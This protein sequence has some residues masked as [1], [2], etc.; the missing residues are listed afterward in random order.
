MFFFQTSLWHYLALR[1]VQDLDER[2]NLHS[3]NF[4]H[5]PFLFTTRIQAH[6]SNGL[7]E[8]RTVG[9]NLFVFIADIILMR[10]SLA[11]WFETN[12]DTLK[13]FELFVY[14]EAITMRKS[15][16]ALD[17]FQGR[18]GWTLGIPNRLLHTV[19]NQRPLDFNLFSLFYNTLGIWTFHHV[20]ESMRRRRSSG[21]T[22]RPRRSR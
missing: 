1:I 21:V 14:T 7:L 15:V 8:T 16:V 5:R 2:F 18:T 22:W 10:E 12:R 13:S 4:F 19:S 11:V 3:T 17:S 9:D 20:R 6:G